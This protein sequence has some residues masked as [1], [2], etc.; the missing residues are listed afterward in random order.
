MSADSAT[1]TPQRKGLLRRGVP[2]Q[3]MSKAARREAIEGYLFLLPNFLG[4]IIFMAIPLLLSLYYS[5]TDY[6]LFNDPNWVGAANYQKAVGF[7]LQP[8]NYQKAVEKGKPFLDAVGQMIKTN[9]PLFW[10]SLSN[11]IVYALG[12]L[13]LSVPTT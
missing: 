5:F 10:T 9:D 8:E 2:R 3:R 12:V 6:N 4:F 1:T 13:L 7:A 11:T